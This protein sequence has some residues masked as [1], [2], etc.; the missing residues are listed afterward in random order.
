[1]LS[2][3]W[4]QWL[5]RSVRT[6]G[7]TW[8]RRRAQRS[9]TADRRFSPPWLE[10]LEDRTVPSGGYVF[11]TIDDPLAVPGPA[12]IPG[13][14]AIG[15]TDRL[16]IIGYHSDVN[17][18]YHSFLFTNGQ[19]V[20]LPDEPQ[21]GTAPSEGTCAISTSPAGQI[22]GFYLNESDGPPGA[23]QHAFSLL[24]GRFTN[25]DI[26]NTEDT[27]AEGINA[28]GVIVGIYAYE[29]LV[30]HGF[31]LSGGQYT[32]L[33]D[34]NAG[35][36]YQQGTFPVAIN[37]AGQI[38]GG[39]TDANG[40]NHGFLFSGGQYTTIDDPN[41]AGTTYANGI[42]DSGQIVGNYFDANGID[43][44]FLLSG[45]QYT[46]V[47]NPN[48]TT[49]SEAQAIN[50]H[51]QIAGIYLDSNQV[52]HGYEATPIGAPASP[53]SPNAL[54]TAL[55]DKAGRA[56]TPA[57]F[58]KVVVF[59][60]PAPVLNAEVKGSIPSNVPAAPSTL[61][62]PGLVSISEPQ[63]QTSSTVRAAASADIDVN[64]LDQLLANLHAPLATGL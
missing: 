33:D 49:R 51:G 46:T 3:K 12:Q 5:R 35:N 13:T 58:G 47:D 18:V 32:T 8:S 14:V 21:A 11:H 59:T 22:V 64:V 31:M 26:P 52:W 24:D 56:F 27:L 62:G 7:P 60:P 40:A 61:V 28:S 25:L 53:S 19:Y 34:P 37:A 20:E 9:R 45:S 17:G 36:G 2:S 54:A 16:Q 43:H 44:G 1:M 48:S 63:G 41:A 57:L 6:N 50:N 4:Y 29:D 38:V 42:N 10:L 23:T 55:S 30:I 39:Y 15:I